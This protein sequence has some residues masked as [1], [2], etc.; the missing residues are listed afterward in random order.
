MLSLEAF[1]ILAS[2]IKLILVLLDLLLSIF[3]V[4]S[5]LVQMVF[6][7]SSGCNGLH[8]ESLFAIQLILEI[9]SF[10]DKLIVLLFV[11]IFF[12]DSCLLLL[13]LL[14]SEFYF[15]S[16][17]LRE[18][19]G[20]SSDLIKFIVDLGLELLCLLDLGEIAALKTIFLIFELSYLVLELYNM[21]VELLFVFLEFLIFELFRLNLCCESFNDLIFV[22]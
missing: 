22:N 5:C 17:H 20:I 16:E 9:I 21:A 1:N 4:S 19:V 11:L 3:K 14:L 7:V 10:L 12:L 8:G 15:N 6:H 18:H 13:F 2:L